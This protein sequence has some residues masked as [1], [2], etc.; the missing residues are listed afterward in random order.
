MPLEWVDYRDA[1]RLYHTDQVA[2][3]C[4]RPLMRLRGGICAR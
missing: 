2:Y 3:E 1:V 4:G